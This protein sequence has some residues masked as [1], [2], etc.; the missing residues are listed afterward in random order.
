MSGTR[1]PL[2]PAVAGGVVQELQFVVSYLL[3]T[4]PTGRIEITKRRADAVMAAHPRLHVRIDRFHDR[5][6]ISLDDDAG[7]DMT[8]MVF[9]G[10]EA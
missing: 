4:R 1:K 8:P 2:A 7:A 3:A 9:Y 10:D 5:L 6:V